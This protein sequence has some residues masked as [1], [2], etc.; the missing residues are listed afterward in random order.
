[1]GF[2]V[3]ETSLLCPRVYLRHVLGAFDRGTSSPSDYDR[4]RDTADHH[5]SNPSQIRSVFR[6]IELS[7]GY[8]GYL[9][10]HEIYVYLLDTVS[11]L[12]TLYPPCH[13]QAAYVDQASSAHPSQLPLFLGITTYI[14][15]WPTKFLTTDRKVFREEDR[16]ASSVDMVQHSTLQHGETS[17]LEDTGTGVSGTPVEK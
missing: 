16:D 14:Y 8:V 2:E 10:T 5:S 11:T 7:E 4:G 17:G 12:C 9:A 15:F 3:V 13:F 6:A 1:M